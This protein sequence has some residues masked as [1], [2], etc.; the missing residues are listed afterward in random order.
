MIF[1]STY[2]PVNMNRNTCTVHSAYKSFPEKELLQAYEVVR[3]K[4]VPGI[5]YEDGLVMFDN[6]FYCWTTAEV[7]LAMEAYKNA[8]ENNFSFYVIKSEDGEP[9]LFVSKA[10]KGHRLIVDA[11]T[12]HTVLLGN[13]QLINRASTLID[14]TVPLRYAFNLFN[15]FKAVESGTGKLVSGLILDRD[16]ADETY[17]PNSMIVNFADVSSSYS[18][19]EITEFRAILEDRSVVTDSFKC[20]DNYL[21]RHDQVEW[22]PVPMEYIRQ[23]VESYDKIKE[24]KNDYTALVDENFITR[25]FVSKNLRYVVNAETFECV[26][27]K[28]QFLKTLLESYMC[29]DFV[30]RDELGLTWMLAKAE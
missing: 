29:R 12:M 18:I 24:K 25:L 27:I 5:D 21:I 19:D 17:V 30:D 7:Y 22:P 28:N 3:G 26:V 10:F 11:Y 2:I 15:T 14:K 20:E 23:L 16:T 13:K 8:K 9:C 4:T 1:T 6:N